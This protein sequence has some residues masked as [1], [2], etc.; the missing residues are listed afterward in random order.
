MITKKE[1]VGSELMREI[2]AIRIDTLWKMLSLK[3]EE[4]LPEVEDE[5]A[6]GAF[7]NK[8][9]IFV[10]GG[11]VYGDVDG[12]PIHYGPD[13]DIG[14]KDFKRNIRSA[15]HYD[16]ATFT[17]EEATKGLLRETKLKKEEFHPTDL[18]AEYKDIKVVGVLRIYAPT[19]PGKRSSRTETRL[20]SP[21]N[22]LGLDIQAMEKEARERYEVR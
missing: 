18:Y 15:M 21:S 8:G 7:D 2:I 6:T 11:L 3:I 9:A 16:N 14:R 1:L 12:N 17:L 19:T 5:G 20:V 4:R 22:D 13:T 10:P